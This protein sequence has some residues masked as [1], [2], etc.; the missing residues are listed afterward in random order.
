VI[1]SYD[2]R[3]GCKAPIP[4]AVR[5]AIEELDRRNDQSPPAAGGL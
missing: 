5:A 4:G 2:Y 1:V 3:N